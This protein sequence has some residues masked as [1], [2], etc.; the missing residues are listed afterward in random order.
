M[1][2]AEAHAWRTRVAFLLRPTGAEGRSGGA[3]GRTRVAF[4]LR[5]AALHPSFLSTESTEKRKSILLVPLHMKQTLIFVVSD[6][7]ALPTRFIHF[8]S[9][10]HGFQYKSEYRTMRT[11][12]TFNSIH[13]LSPTALPTR[14]LF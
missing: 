7:P 10:I 9:P 5:L 13:F 6:Q 14:F 3:E 1:C 4:L 2:T 11:P 8:L 12:P